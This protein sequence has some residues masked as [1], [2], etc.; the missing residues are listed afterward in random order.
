M[1]KKRK[2]ALYGV[3]GVL[4]LLFV[5]MNIFARSTAHGLVTQ[6][7][8]ERDPIDEAPSDYGIPFEEVTVTSEDG[9]TLHGWYIPTQNGATVMVQHG[10]TSDRTAGLEEADI[11]Y[12][13]GYGVLVTSVR[14]HDLNEGELITFGL[15]EMQDMDAWY[16]FLLVQDEFDNDKLGIIG[17]SMGGS[18]VIQYAAQNESI[19]VIVANSPFSSLDDTISTSVTYFT[20]L[21]PF[22]FAPMIAFWAEQEMGFQTSE[23]NATLWVAELSPR[24]IL[25]MQ[26]GQDVVVSVTSG[27]TLYEAA[28]EPKELWYEPELGHTDFDRDMPEEYE[29]RVI[30][31][32]DAYLL[33][34]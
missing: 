31:L 6:P 17:N 23:I 20:G 10:Y 21:P 7:F 29:R 11:L 26:G 19:G 2:I 18:I 1:N 32:L 12:R 3:G 9:L 24:P 28:G 30:A 25:L 13:N 15:L 8:E 22:P 27:E 5:A 4:L 14:T 34:D 33:G 16:Q